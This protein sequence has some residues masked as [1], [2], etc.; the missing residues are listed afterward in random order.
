MLPIPVGL[1]VVKKKK[2]KPAYLE[3]RDGRP[4]WNP[5]PRLKSRGFKGRDLKRPDG[6][7]M[8]EGE[9][10]HAA[11]A[12]NDAITALPAAPP[13]P[14]ET[15]TMTALFD[16]IRKSPKLAKPESPPAA[17]VGGNVLDQAQ[18]AK[19]RVGMEKL[20]LSADTIAG[21]RQA[22]AI[23]ETWCG[24]VEVKALTGEMIEDFYHDQAAGRGLAMA[25]ALLRVLKLAFNIAIEKMRWLDVNPVRAVE[26]ATPDG[27]LEIFEPDQIAVILA[28]ADWC[29]LQSVGDAFVIGVLA[30]QRKADILALPEGDMTAGHYVIKQRKGW[31]HGATAYVPITEP[32]LLRVTAMRR[33]KAE[34]CPGV[35]HTMEVIATRTGK[36]YAAGAKMFDDEWRLVRA[37]ASGDADAIA[38]VRA[39]RKLNSTDLPFAPI[40]AVRRKFFSDTRDTAVTFLCGAGCSVPEIANITGHSLKTVEAILNKHY[41]K[42]N[43]ALA[44]SAGV[45]HDAYLA[46]L[47]IRWA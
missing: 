19:R 13:P 36:P 20:R 16:R 12:L 39:E 46:T 17:G 35:H 40:P 2:F 22:L 4:R 23:L 14:P 47:N 44:I 31:K 26:M 37:V 32:L 38:K 24:D 30:G 34:S 21:Y 43:A 3:W 28:A 6:T 1:S 15:R 45:K 5:G 29:G 41:F 33:R 9:A 7:W 25:N 27:R 42:R 8:D 10:I 11:R 18:D